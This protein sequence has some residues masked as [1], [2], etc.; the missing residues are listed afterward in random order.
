MGKYIRIR[1]ESKPVDR[2]YFEKLGAGNKSDDDRTIGQFGSGACYAPLAA[3]RSGREYVV[4]GYDNRGT[5]KLTYRSELVDGINEVFYDY[6]DGEEVRDSSFTLEAGKLSWNDPWQ[7]FR[8]AMSNAI[9]EFYE[10]GAEYDVSIVD[11]IE[12]PVDGYVSVYI[13]ADVEMRKIVRKIDQYFS[14]NRE[15]LSDT[16]YG[17]I[18]AKG[19]DPVLHVYLKGVLVYRGENE[20]LF[21]YDFDDIDLNEERTIR[22]LYAMNGSISQAIASTTSKSVISPFISARI[23]NVH[24]NRLGKYE[25]C[26]YL[27]VQKDWVDAFRAAFGETAYPI[28]SDAAVVVSDALKVKG[29]KAIPCPELLVSILKDDFPALTK[30]L[31]KQ[32]EF[33]DATL[34]SHLKSVLDEAVEIVK[35]HEPELARFKIRVFEPKNGQTG[36]LGQADRVNETI[37]IN[38]C[39]LHD[40]LHKTVATLIHEADHLISEMGDN[41]REFRDQADLRLAMFMV[42]NYKK[43]VDVP[44]VDGNFVVGH[45]A[46]GETEYSL[47]SLGNDL[48]LSFGGNVY[49]L[50]GAIADSSERVSDDGF[51]QIVKGKLVI[52][53]PKSVDLGNKVT[54]KVIN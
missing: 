24:E 18:L 46:A 21:D 51:V 23:K 44:V 16:R 26:S 4:C 49:V 13:T 36:I 31:G 42:E 12:P 10:Y 11:E 37:L 34:D 19:N 48:L 30:I 45:L 5:F 17:K 47:V 53:V 14:M 7:I 41:T 35:A 38:V 50:I 15:V 54:A 28:V 32:T 52:P 22:S 40:G 20:S 8:E 6:N 9:D 3:L 39:N 29:Y 2:R 27:P 33:N 25:I 43:M 1:N